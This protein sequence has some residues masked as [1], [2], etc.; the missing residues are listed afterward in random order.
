MV[1][2]NQHIVGSVELVRFNA[3]A[4]NDIQ[5]NTHAACAV[6]PGSGVGSQL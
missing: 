6:L 3:V 4:F 2:A 1:R 5:R